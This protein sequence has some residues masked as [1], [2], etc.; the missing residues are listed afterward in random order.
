MTKPQPPLYITTPIY[1][2]N[3]EP[4]IGHAYTTVLA[5][6]LAR[7]HRLMGAETRFQTGT[8]E[9]GEKVVEAARARGIP[10][11]DYVDQISGRFRGTWDQMQI[12]YDHFI[13]TTDPLHIQVV[14]YVL[15]KVNSQG[16]IYFSE[17]A[18]HYCYGCERFVLERELVDGKCPDHQV[19]PTYVKE[20]N[21]FFRMS[22]YQDW[23]IEYIQTHTDFIRPERYRNEVLSFLKEPLEDLCIS[24]PR[25]RVQWGIPLP[26]DDNYV[27]YVWFDAL[28]NYL[29]G[30]GYPD[31]TL[32]KKF[33]PAC[34]HLI[35][36]DILKPHGIYWP[37]I[38]KATGLEP[39]HHLNVHGYWQIGQGKMSKTLGNVV[40]PQRL[41]KQYGLDQ[42]R[43]FFLREMVYGLDAVFSEDALVGRINADLANDLGNLFSRSLAM[44][45]KYRQGV[46]PEAGPYESADEELRSLAEMVRG[47]Y[48]GYLPDLEFHKALQRLW[49]LIGEINRYIVVM[50]PWKLFKIQEQQRLNTVLYTI[51]EGLRWVTVMLR[52]LL[53]ASA[54]R[55]REQLGLSPD[56]WDSGLFELLTWGRLPTG[57]QLIKGA[58]LFPRLET[59]EIK[60][61]SGGEAVF[62]I[63]PFKPQVELAV[64]QQLDLRVGRIIAAAKIPKSDKL[65]KLSV[66]IGEVRQVV[67]GIAQH[68]EPAEIIGRQVII[69]ANLKPAKLMGIESQGM[70][71]A[72][73]SE[74]RLL[75]LSP[76]KDVIPGSSVS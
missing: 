44:V 69:V 50:E 16:D 27:T 29:T 20:G 6:T 64:F 38:L 46:V 58:P 52:P 28:I 42:V 9:H 51:L 43:Y 75:L 10:V 67:A 15:N 25:A 41:V 72:A 37:T 53:P 7:F 30:L 17:Y 73:K 31:Q 65:L 45:F 57:V 33:W 11:K 47:D 66:D 59:L 12:S 23:L 8:D 49:E 13:R 55:M 70:V 39:Y 5:D 40:E 26:F 62:P 34:Q 24:R 36:K 19:K 56:T 48:L 35:A 1:Y 32:V 14:Q 60:S 3:A 18:G 61:V 22:R 63:Q 74:G 76:E 2:V 21:Y 4:H 71:L 54:D 68:Y